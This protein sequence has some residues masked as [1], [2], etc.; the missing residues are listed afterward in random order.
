[1]SSAIVEHV[2]KCGADPRFTRRR[3]KEDPIVVAER[4]NR[5]DGA[6]SKLLRRYDS[7]M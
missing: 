6:V 3:N 1:V 5:G 7:N 4:N 2:L